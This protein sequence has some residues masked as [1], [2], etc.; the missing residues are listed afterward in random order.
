MPVNSFEEYPMS[1][2][3]YLE[4]SDDPIYIYLA[5]L[6]K[7]DIMSGK[8]TPGTKL[9]P[10]RELADYLD[11]NLST[12][13]R[14]FKLCEQKGLICSAVGRGTY[15][16][17]DAASQGMMCINAPDQHIIE[18]GAILP[19]PDINELASNYLKDMVKEPDFYKVLQYGTVEYDELQIKAACKW[20]SYF[21]IASDKSHILFSNGSQNAIFAMMSA[22]FKSGDKIAT[23]PVTYPGL[24]MAAKILGIQLIALPLYD[25]KIT[26]DSLDYVYKNTNVKGFYFIPDFNNPTSEIMDLDTRKMI[27]AY[28]ER[29]HLPVIEDAI[30]SLFIPS[31]LPPVA[32][33]APNFGLLISSVSKIMSPGLRLALMHVPAQFHAIIRECLY[34]MQITSPTLMMQ[35]FTRLVLSGQ[36]E[37]IRRLRIEEIEERYAVFQ[38]VCGDLPATVNSHSP[39]CWLTLP[40]NRNPD[41]FEQTALQHGLQVYSA[42]RFVVGS[43]KVPNNIRLS[44]IS[45][46][47][48]QKYREGLHILRKIIEEKNSSGMEEIMNRTYKL[49]AF[50]MDGTLLNSNKQISEENL[51]AINKAMR[52]EKTVILNTG[53]CLAELDEFLTQIPELR[54]VNCVS[55]AL[56]YDVKEKKEIYAQKL[57][58][59]TIQQ[60]FQIAEME[61]AMPQLLNAESIVSTEFVEHM[62]DYHM[63]IY[64]PLFVRVATKWD[65]LYEQYMKS[66]FEAAKFNLYHTSKESRER[67]EQ[68]IKEAGLD[69]ELVHAEVSNLEISAKGVDKGIGLERL[70][71]YLQISC[72]ETIAVGDAANDIGA[73]KTAGLAVA[74]GN[75]RTA[76]KTIADVIVSDCDH[77]GCAEAIEKY[78]L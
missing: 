77:F 46:H 69:V 22:L 36:F 37:E 17:S 74:M 5:K 72:E 54:Y 61:Q 39:I 9:P 40:D 7:A 56:V 14:A 21:D 41:E 10:Q 67:T 75:A 60:L 19:N 32:T 47:S 44:L 63:D 62:E 31:P 30:Y 73:M 70:C 24:K 12:I 43:E 48:L 27:G 16:S 57:S 18:M 78:L 35:L 11:V 52:Q 51:H 38:E 50:D 26:E 76:V 25:G 1:W 4:P 68:R 29:H 42:S 65:N 3:P 8:L 20:F 58:V 28:A 34:A 66:P 15:V 45:E 71:E 13:T 33:F 64:K 23:L 53:R 6:L 55:G 59:E 2:K 49:I